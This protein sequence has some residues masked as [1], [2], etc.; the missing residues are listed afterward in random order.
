MAITAMASRLSMGT[1]NGP[2]MRRRMMALTSSSP[3]ARWDQAS[4]VHSTP[5]MNR[6]ASP[7]HRKAR[8]TEIPSARQATPKAASGDE[9]LSPTGGL[10]AR[11]PSAPARL[12]SSSASPSRVTTPTT[13][14]NRAENAAAIRSV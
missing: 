10:T 2:S 1:S 12:A 11:T 9:M 4:T 14:R 6:T 5:T 13:P 3:V 8:D 7:S